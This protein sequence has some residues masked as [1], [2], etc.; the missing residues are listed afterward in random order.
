MKMLTKKPG[1]KAKLELSQFGLV[2]ALFFLILHLLITEERSLY[3]SIAI[4]FLVVSLF[5][6]RLFSPLNI[7]WRKFGEGMGRIVG[8]L[9]LGIV[10]FVLLT[11]IAVFRRLLSGS[12]LSLDL[13]ENTGSFWKAR[14]EGEMK[15][16]D[17][18]RQ[19]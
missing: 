7:I 10:F 6:P 19:F 2:F 5:S 11:P 17:F 1:D 3:V 9:L 12:V 16:K 14:K 18:E 8:S 15:E 13:S 4:V